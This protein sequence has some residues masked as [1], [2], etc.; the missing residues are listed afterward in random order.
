VDVLSFIFLP[1]AEVLSWLAFIMMKYIVVVVT[2]FANLSFAVIDLTF[3]LWMMIIFYL[4]IIFWV[5]K[6]SKTKKI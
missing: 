3:S 5:Y 4:L 1:L 2:F 6:H